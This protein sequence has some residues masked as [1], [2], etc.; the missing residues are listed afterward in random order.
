V[1][2]SLPLY[3]HQPPPPSGPYPFSSFH[4]SILPTNSLYLSLCLTHTSHSPWSST[5]QQMSSSRS[6]LLFGLVAA[7]LL[8]LLLVC[9]T[10]PHH[11]VHAHGTVWPPPRSFT[12]GDTVIGIDPEQFE[13]VVEYDKS[14]LPSSMALL[15]RAV[16]RYQNFWMFPFNL[17]RERQEATVDKAS[18]R[19]QVDHELMEQMELDKEA[20]DVGIDIDENDPDKQIEIDLLEFDSAESL[21]RVTLQK[22]IRRLT[23]FVHSCPDL[24]YGVKESYTLDV[25][26]GNDSRLTAETC[27]G[28]IRGLESFSQLVA[29][30]HEYVQYVIRSTPLTII[31]NPRFHWRYR[32]VRARPLTHQLP[33]RNSL[34]HSLSHR[35]LMLDTAGRYVPV[36]TIFQILDAMSWA[37]LNVFHWHLSDD[38]SFPV[39]TKSTPY[40]ARGAFSRKQIYTVDMLKLVVAHA[41]DR[42]IRVIPEF[43]MPAHATSWSHG[44]ESQS[45]TL[46]QL[47]VGC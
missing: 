6:H 16:R 31:D 9:C 38:Q 11:G 18:I 4:L 32:V 7:W 8:L 39:L 17:T 37:K 26:H 40:L 42:G 21:N 10:L 25:T 36:R 19:Q 2:F 1:L 20:S 27:Y 35:G 13:I 47:S 28:A 14:M 30:D 29:W 34:I 41:K 12:L 23:V 33:F 15:R 24:T 22:Y 5:N 46:A 3:Q 45:L 43:E 44:T